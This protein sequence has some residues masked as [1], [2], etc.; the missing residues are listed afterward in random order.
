[1]IKLMAALLLINSPIVSKPVEVKM[2]K[3]SWGCIADD[4]MGSALYTCTYDELPVCD[5]RQFVCVDSDT[6]ECKNRVVNLGSWYP[7]PSDNEWHTSFQK[8]PNPQPKMQ[9][10]PGD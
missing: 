5:R 3:C 2:L 7:R 1:M 8:G 10:M 4:R 9:L 6:I